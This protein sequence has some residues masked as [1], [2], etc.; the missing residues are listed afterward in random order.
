MLRGSCFLYRFRLVLGAVFLL[1]ELNRI[2][3]GRKDP[4]TGVFA[5]TVRRGT[6]YPFITNPSNATK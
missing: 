5:E 2:L 6:L 3:E 4:L 1:S